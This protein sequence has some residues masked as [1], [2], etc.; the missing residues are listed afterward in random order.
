MT[1]EAATLP[2]VEE[3]A[4]AKTE[5]QI[6]M[7]ELAAKT[8]QDRDAEIVANG[9]EVVDTLNIADDTPA[10]VIVDEPIKHPETITPES[11]TPTIPDVEYVTVKVD[12]H[13]R[14]VLKSQIIEAGA[15]A[16]KNPLPISDAGP[17]LLREAQESHPNR[18]FTRYG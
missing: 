10:A 6:M 15:H 9:G 14:Q 13:E 2:G 11:A 8:R 17:S 7:D 3:Q 4:P 5:R 1:I 16:Q 12:G 18:T